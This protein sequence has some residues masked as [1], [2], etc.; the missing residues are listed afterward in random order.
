MDLL[1]LLIDFRAQSKIQSSI[2]DGEKATNANALKS[3]SNKR[4]GSRPVISPSEFLNNDS[5]FT[6]DDPMEHVKLRYIDVFTLMR[7]YAAQSSNL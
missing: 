4:D 7:N 6:S 2:Q 5:R 1:A 3:K